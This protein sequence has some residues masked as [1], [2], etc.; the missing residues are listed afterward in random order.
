MKYYIFKGYFKADSKT[1]VFHQEGAYSSCRYKDLRSYWINM[2]KKTTVKSGHITNSNSL[3]VLEIE[4]KQI[5]H[6]LPEEERQKLDREV[7]VSTTFNLELISVHT[8]HIMVAKTHVPKAHSLS[9][10]G[11]QNTEAGKL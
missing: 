5:L 7:S 8:S 9:D 11:N 2:L 10:L 6:R 1:M 4:Q 3:K